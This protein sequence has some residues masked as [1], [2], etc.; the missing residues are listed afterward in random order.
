VQAN[1][2]FFDPQR[3]WKVGSGRLYSKSRNTPLE[4]QVLKGKVL[5]AINNG[6]DWWWGGD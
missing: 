1:L 5:G 3:S 2:T 6:E 4:G